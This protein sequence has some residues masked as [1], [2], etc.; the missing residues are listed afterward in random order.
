MLGFL[1]FPRAA[2]DFWQMAYKGI[3]KG[4]WNLIQKES[5]KQTYDRRCRYTHIPNKLNDW[6]KVNEIWDTDR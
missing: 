3:F 4:K 2:F 5:E 1:S 6:Q